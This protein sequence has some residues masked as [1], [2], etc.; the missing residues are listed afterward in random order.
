MQVGPE[1]S[2]TSIFAISGSQKIYHTQ[3]Y[4]NICHRLNFRHI[5]IF[6]ITK[7]RL[8]ID[9]LSYSLRSPL[10]PPVLENKQVSV[11]DLGLLELYGKNN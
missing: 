4:S 8:I 1:K 6:L 9:V 10:V 11:W 3:K 7:N 5:L 2:K